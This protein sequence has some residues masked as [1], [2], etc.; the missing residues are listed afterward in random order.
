MHWEI[1]WKLGQMMCE[2]FHRYEQNDINCTRQTL[3][4]QAGRRWIMPHSM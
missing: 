1:G 3:V 4:I 2:I